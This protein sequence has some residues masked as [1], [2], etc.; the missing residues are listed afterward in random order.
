MAERAE[1]NPATEAVFQRSLAIVGAICN[2]GFAAMGYPQKD[3]D[4]DLKTL[5]LQEMLDAVKIV[6][7]RGPVPNA[8]G[9][10]TIHVI[11]DDRLTAAVY[12]LVNYEFSREA[13]AAIGSK[14][15]AVVPMK[16]EG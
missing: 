14:V 13:I 1:N 5:S 2:A 3:T 9:G 12:A 16:Q 4:V 10:H 7:D 6:A 11:P 15:I 8:S